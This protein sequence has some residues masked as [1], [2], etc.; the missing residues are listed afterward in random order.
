M[1]AY[2]QGCSGV[3]LPL[4][5]LLV[6]IGVAP[7]DGGEDPCSIQLAGL[8]IHVSAYI[9]SFRCFLL[10]LVSLLVLIGVVPGDDGVTGGQL[11]EVGDGSRRVWDPA[12]V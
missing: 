3:L 10:L 8:G 12:S 2:I 4:V 11:L 9:K 1:S 6:V 7:G 5:S